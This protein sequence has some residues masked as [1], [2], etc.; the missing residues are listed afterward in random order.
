MQGEVE[1]LRKALTET[2]TL[3]DQERARFDAAKREGAEEL[4]VLTPL[5]AGM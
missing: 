3:L 5:R 1:K 2:E 4:Q